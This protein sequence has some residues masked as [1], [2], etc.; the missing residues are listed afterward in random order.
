[1]LRS[2]IH[3]GVL[4]EAYLLGLPLHPLWPRRGVHA[5]PLPRLAEPRELEPLDSW[6]VSL[7]GTTAEQPVTQPCLDWLR[8]VLG[9][10]DEFPP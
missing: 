4:G 6:Y 2:K 1:M 5:P 9:L 8:S 10:L 3:A 7:L